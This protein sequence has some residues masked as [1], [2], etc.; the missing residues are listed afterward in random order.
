MPT[1][2]KVFDKAMGRIYRS[3][4][5]GISWEMI[6]E[7]E[8]LVRYLIIHPND[9]NTLFASLGIFD[10]EAN[11]SNCSLV[12][13]V[14]GTGGVIKLA[15]Q[16]SG[17]DIWY[18][19]TAKGL[20]D[21]NVGSLV[22]HPENPDI[23]IAGAGNNAC[24]I[25]N[26]NNTWY[27]TGGV[28]LTTNG[29]NTWTKT[30]SNDVITS[31]EFAPSNP[32]IAYAGS[33]NKIY[34]STNGGFTWTIISG[35]DYPW[36]P[37]GV[38]SGFPIDFLVHP[39]NPNTI[40]SNNYGGG[41]VLS[42]D[43]G[44][45]WELASQGYTGALMLGVDANPQQPAL[46][47][48]AARSGAFRSLV[49]GNE[50]EGISHKPAHLPSVYDIAVKPDEPNIILVSQELL[51]KIYRSTDHGKDWKEVF[52]LPG[53]VPGQDVDQHGLK[54]I[55]FAP[56]PNSNVVYAGSCRGSV[57]LDAKI[58]AS[59]GVWKS[60][61]GGETWNEAND[62]NINTKCI[63]DL[64]V[65]VGNPNVIYAAS[66]AGGLYKTNN[67][68]SNWSL[69]STLPATNVH[70]VAVHPTNSMVIY[71]GTFNQGVY[72]STNAGASWTP[73]TAG[74]EPNDYIRSL[75]I[76]PADPDIIW[77]GSW[78]T[79]V[80]R[81]VPSEGRWAHVNS[82]LNTR[83]VMDL[84]ISPDGSF[85]YAASSGEGVFRLGDPP[86]WKHYMPIVTH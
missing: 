59:K 58:T 4:D 77:A 82:G 33:Q 65:Q 61:D 30:L 34:K 14:Q 8:N 74:M 48:S 47:Y 68:G 81:W 27:N 60:T 62:T 71:A 28:F 83:S 50:W 36:G 64:A 52:I 44:V 1:K 18:L 85:L 26:H 86:P 22:M 6:W 41:N 72:K 51:G 35:T 70:S 49:G 17:W 13:P 23:L 42:V 38:Q 10:R 31:V 3:E 39:D 2:G 25:Y 76:D 79:G 66:P 32:N 43:G 63:A 37:E 16:G 19:D 12:P 73:M 46:V 53:I 69:L 78:S 45:E 55:V 21:H 67:G 56:P 11:D 84:F 7:G 40:Y 20:T 57:A 15:K 5:G 24:S 54:R 80:Y 29:G 9:P 75:V